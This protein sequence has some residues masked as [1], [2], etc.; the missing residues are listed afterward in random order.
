MMVP[1][2]LDINSYFFNLISNISIIIIIIIIVV[3]FVILF[4]LLPTYFSLGGKAS[5]PTFFLLVTDRK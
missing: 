5:E 4:F 1:N 2:F 3:V